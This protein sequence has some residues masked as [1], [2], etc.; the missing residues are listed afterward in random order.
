MQTRGMRAE[1][2]VK[3]LPALAGEEVKAPHNIIK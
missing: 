2:P 1:K 3:N